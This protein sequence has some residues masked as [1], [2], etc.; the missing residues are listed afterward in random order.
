MNARV[1]R[2]YDLRGHAERDLPDAFVSDLGRAIATM[3][4]A[5]GATRITL[6]RD[7]RLSSPRIH[8]ALKEQLLSAGL[9]VVDV[10]IVHTPGL[11]FSVF[12]LG[13]DGGVM[14]T[15]SHNPSEDNGFKIVAGRSTIHGA[16]IQ[17]L[18][19]CIKA[20][21]FR[22]T[23]RPGT[24]SAHAI[25]PDYIATI[26]GNVRLGAR[27]PEVI[28]DGGNGTGGVALMPILKALGIEAEGIF[29]EPDGRF[30]NHHP[31]PTVPENLQALSARVRET[32]AEVGIALDGDADRIGAVDG[33]GRIVWGDQLMMLFAREILKDKPGATFV[34]E[35][36]CSQALF[37]EITALGGKAIMWKV[38]HSLI[39]VKMK[40]ENAALAG[41]MSGHM[42]FAD[43]W[44]G[45]DDAVYAGARLIELLSRGPAT[46]AQHYD[47]LP[48]LHN[49]PE[50]R[51]DCPEEI[52]FEVVRRT[53]AWFRERH[54]V[55]DIDGGRISFQE[56]GRT[57][58]WGLVRAS[59][60]GA[61]LV[62]R[63]EADSA[64]RLSSIRTLVED[65]LH[66][67]IAETAA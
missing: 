38:G 14:I 5:R 45:F 13:A 1:F 8:A 28:V 18:L 43:R 56:D 16:E 29:C 61:V 32:G 52:K 46:M 55:V 26:V 12:H 15:A 44:Y 24:A 6:G 7:C 10:G 17:N 21:A 64:G 36:K 66:Q 27:R 37:D 31:D 42:F 39:K 60:T 57:V 23:G 67:I 3:F 53:V 25:L 11:Y 48:A 20:R 2:E 50:I 19:A 49:T 35:V 63:F 30:P 47:T 41:E 65:R 22:T 34:S 33:K 54:P 62:L 58:G 59:N 51:L 4:V 9:D 40:E